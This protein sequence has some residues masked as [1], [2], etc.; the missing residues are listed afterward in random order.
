MVLLITCRIRTNFVGVSDR[1][2]TQSMLL[3]RMSPKI[4]PFK[5]LGIAKLTLKRA[6]ASVPLFVARL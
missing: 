3:F 1:D 6:T 4:G 2:V 5:E